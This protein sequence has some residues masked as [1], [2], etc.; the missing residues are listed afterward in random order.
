MEGRKIIQWVL[1]G[2]GITI[3]IGYSCFVLFDFI[4]GPQIII[5]SPLNGL[6]TTTPTIFIKGRIVHANNLTI[7]DMKTAVTLSGDFNGRLILAPGYN[8]IKVAAKD[9]YGR[10]E[11]KTIET[12]LVTTEQATSTPENTLPTTEQAQGDRAGTSTQLIN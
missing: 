12:I 9:N 8:I 2:L 5:E 4:R 7:N 1:S 10:I 6:S 3:V 11:E